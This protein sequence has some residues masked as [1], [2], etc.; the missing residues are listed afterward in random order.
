M[1]KAFVHRLFYGEYYPVKRFY[2]TCILYTLIASLFFTF[3]SVAQLLPQKDLNFGK[4][5]AAWIN[6]TDSSITTTSIDDMDIDKSGN[7]YIIG[8]RA[9]TDEDHFIAR[10]T[11]SGRLDS[12]FTEKGFREIGFGAFS[13]VGAQ[14]VRLNADESRIWIINGAIGRFNTLRTLRMLPNGNND[15]TYGHNGY[16]SGIFNLPLFLPREVVMAK[17]NGLFILGI[18]DPSSG[19]PDSLRGIK[20]TADGEIDSLYNGG[21]PFSIAIPGSLFYQK[22]TLLDDQSLLIT[23][24]N[25]NVSADSGVI[26]CKINPFGQPDSSFG[27]NGIAKAQIFGSSNQTVKTTLLPDGS[28]SLLSFISGN[29]GTRQLKLTASGLP[30]TSFGTKGYKTYPLFKSKP[31]FIFNRYKDPYDLKIWGYQ[32]G[33]QY[34]DSNR[35]VLL[36]LSPSGDLNTTSKYL[37]KAVYAPGDITGYPGIP[38]D[39]PQFEELSFQ[40]A[41]NGFT[42]ITFPNYGLKTKQGASFKMGRLNENIHF[43]SAYGVYGK[44]LVPIKSSADGIYHLQSLS[45]GKLVADIVTDAGRGLTC[46]TKKGT[47]DSSFGNNGFIFIRDTSFITDMVIDAND[48]IITFNHSAVYSASNGYGIIK[49]YLQNGSPDSSFGANGILV[50][51]SRSAADNF[52]IQKGTVQCDNKIL[53]LCQTADYDS[54]RKE[55]LGVLR[56][57]EDGSTDYSF[58]VNGRIIVDLDIDFVNPTPFLAN[59]DIP[60][61]FVALKDTT[62]AVV[63][64]YTDALICYM[65]KLDKNGHIMRNGGNNG[66]YAA[67]GNYESETFF[68]KESDSG[69]II[70]GTKR[71][72]YISNDVTAHLAE[73]SS[74]NHD[75]VYNN[76]PYSTY[77]TKQFADFT[78]ATLLHNENLVVS[79]LQRDSTLDSFNLLSIC[80]KRGGPDSTYGTNGVMNFKDLLPDTATALRSQDYTNKGGFT[81]QTATDDEGQ[82]F[83]ITSA[84][85]NCLRDIFITRNLL[86]DSVAVTAPKTPV[87][88]MN[89]VCNGKSVILLA[90]SPGCTRCTYTWN[91]G[92]TGKNISVHEPGEYSVTV[93]NRGG[94]ASATKMVTMSLPPD[95]SITTSGTNVCKGGEITV[96]ATGASEYY[97]DGPGLITNTGASVTAKPTADAVY[98]VSGKQNGCSAPDSVVV[99][100]ISGGAPSV[101]IAYSGCPSDTIAFQ[102][103]SQNGGSSPVYDWYLN[104]VPVKTGQSIVLS[105]LQNGDKVKCLLTSS[106]DCIVPDTV[107]SAI[108]LNCITTTNP[109]IGSLDYFTISPNPTSDF[110]KL[111]FSLNQP[112][113]MSFV[114]FDIN[115]RPVYSSSGFYDA[116]EYTQEIDM[117]SFMTGIYF[118]RVTVGN[119]KFTREIIKR[120]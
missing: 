102:A 54:K 72:F 36:N 103:S 51:R 78:G 57:N 34:T 104:N 8:S 69:N 21:F 22:A 83:T 23:V 90:N 73:V 65:F 10:L 18:Y 45:S 4:N 7:T 70:V 39:H 13:S 81:A 80:L 41:N 107:S 87:I 37:T 106:G 1:I 119:E 59:D 58:G 52:S 40:S 110:I 89:Q 68:M 19:N 79:A 25:T 47:I 30:D 29:T 3:S 24:N 120:N 97:W 92:E 94:S 77:Y 27:K 111:H 31:T 74:F 108:V 38:G 5:G 109:R 98:R 2:S 48:R 95:I 50:M 113:T 88:T 14:F 49:R 16:K 112:E 53:I 35:F 43:D 11:A 101:N 26:V 60:K 76:Q 118:L 99:K 17:D 71:T 20:F 93:T 46:F 100:I 63:G 9:S 85:R 82:L 86:Y 115:G 28:I 32:S 15:S 75:L 42:F 6:L 114:L 66:R 12:S 116:G 84:E 62:I 55:D 64:S 56:L 33:Y 117:R 105:N 67:E 91:N 44:A 61:N 96:T